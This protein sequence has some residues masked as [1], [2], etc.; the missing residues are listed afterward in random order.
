M[1]IVRWL[2]ALALL[3]LVA[4]ISWG[5]IVAVRLAP[6]IVAPG[7]TA[8]HVDLAIHRGTSKQSATLRV[9]AL[10]ANG[11]PVTGYSASWA[12]SDPAVATVT[13][14]TIVAKAPGFTTAIVH[15]SGGQSAQLLVCVSDTGAAAQ[16]RI[17][18]WPSVS[19]RFDGDF[20]VT[21]PPA[22]QLS[23][24]QITQFGAIAPADSLQLDAYQ[25]A[26]GVPGKPWPQECVH[27]TSTQPAAAAIVG[28]WGLVKNVTADTLRP[29]SLL[30]ARVGPP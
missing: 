23:P 11:F 14:G 19:M 4:P 28:R 20:D 1:R 15:V 18:Q 26:T 5:Q 3:A 13:A 29:G 12:S 27:W 16:P 10:D 8:D 2:F 6:A 22:V 7:D 30:R 24:G 9:V 25:R 17:M 21:H